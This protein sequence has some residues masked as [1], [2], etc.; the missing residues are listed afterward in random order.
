MTAP[1]HS[2]RPFDFMV[3]FWGQ[4]YREYFVDR[5]L[6][7][8]LAPNN[9]TLL[10]Q[11]DGHRFLIAAPREDWD[12]IANLPILDRL[13]RHA[14]PTWIEVEAPNPT[15]T[16]SNRDQYFITVRHQDKCRRILCETA[17]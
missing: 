7:S 16:D 15:L 11:R 8:L 5:C 3:P 9:L 14:T 4:K 12:A 13:R 17:Y 10:D 1:S 6:P 2:L